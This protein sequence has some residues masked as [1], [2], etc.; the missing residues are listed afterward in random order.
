M[1]P[2]PGDGS[3]GVNVLSE[4]G[5][6]RSDLTTSFGSASGA[7]DGVPVTVDL[8]VYDL[9]GKEGEK[10]LPGY[11][12]FISWKDLY[13]VYG[14]TTEH[15]YSI[16][17]AI[18]FTNELY[19]VP[20]DYSG[21]ITAGELHRAVGKTLGWDLLRSTFFQVTKQNDTFLFEGQGR[22]HGVGLC[23]TGADARGAA[24]MSWQVRR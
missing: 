19:D 24:G 15:F 2:Y 17:G 1:N 12:Y 8:K 10:L 6:V 9:I 13:T 11:R 23:Q 4:S 7:A 5:I 21:T 14:S 16:H 22:G 3:N 18:A 20:A